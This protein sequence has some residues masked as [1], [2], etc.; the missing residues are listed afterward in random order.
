M[1]GRP[2]EN[3]ASGQD[4]R[5]LAYRLKMELRKLERQGT[6]ETPYA[7][8]LRRVLKV[9]S[10][11]DRDAVLQM[12]EDE[13]RSLEDGGNDPV[14]AEALRKILSLI[15]PAG[16][17]R[18]ELFSYYLGRLEAEGRGD[19]PFAQALRKA[20]E[21]PDGPSADTLFERADSNGNR[22]TA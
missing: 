10:E 19:E 13:I 15:E 21:A 1:N 8:A 16:H 20:L 4:N 11:F 22:S 5:S 7:D 18:R 2:Q 12:I 17:A 14:L 6:G 3:W 9:T